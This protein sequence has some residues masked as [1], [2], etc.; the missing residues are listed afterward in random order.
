MFQ[1]WTASKSF[2]KSIVH[3]APIILN[4]V[5]SHKSSNSCFFLKALS[6]TTLFLNGKVGRIS[7]CCVIITSI[8][9]KRWRMANCRK[10]KGTALKRKEGF[11][12][13][14][15]AA[16]AAACLLAG[17]SGKRHG[18]GGDA[19]PEVRPLRQGNGVTVWCFENMVSFHY[20][21]L[22]SLLF[23]FLYF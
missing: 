21:K 22:Y 10:E 13:G 7:R 11:F 17:C 9:Q 20:I 15:D 6:K 1:E 5:S 14:V 23:F 2:V 12:W 4:Q 8:E 3:N 19:R 18:G 16:A